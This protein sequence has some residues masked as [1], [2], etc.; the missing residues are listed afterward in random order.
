MASLGMAL[1]SAHPYLTSLLV[2]ALFGIVGAALLSAAT[3]PEPYDES[4]A[5]RARWMAGED[6]DGRPVDP[7]L[8]EAF[9]TDT[10]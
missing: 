10:L 8:E 7:E 6:P 1:M 9:K 5:R 2:Y 4:S 3:A